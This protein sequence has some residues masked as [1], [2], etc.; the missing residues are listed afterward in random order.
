[1]F[2]RF[3]SH[4]LAA[5]FL[6]AT[7]LAAAPAAAQGISETTENVETIPADAT[8]LVGVF[9]RY[10]RSDCSENENNPPEFSELEILEAP[11]HGKLLDFGTGYI[12]TGNNCV[13][14]SRIV[15]YK[16]DADFTGED[17]VSIKDPVTGVQI[18]NIY[19]YEP[20]KWIFKA[21]EQFYKYEPPRGEE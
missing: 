3:C 1:M 9:S 6:T 2:T 19:K 10:R 12:E 16:S 14:N 7:V 13:I 8:D 20:E 5:T 18:V 4:L 11:A 17:R 15:G 21:Y